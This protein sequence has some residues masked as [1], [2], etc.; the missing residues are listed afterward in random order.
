[1]ASLRDTLEC[2]SI[3][4]ARI[5]VLGDLFGHSAPAQMSANPE[6]RPVFHQVLR[7]QWNG[8]NDNAPHPQNSRRDATVD[9][10]VDGGAGMVMWTPRWLVVGAAFV[11]AS[12]TSGCEGTA[13]RSHYILESGV[14][15]GDELP[16]GQ[17]ICTYLSVGGDMVAADQKSVDW[18]G[19]LY[20]EPLSGTTQIYVARGSAEETAVGCRH[21]PDGKADT[22]AST[23]RG[24]TC[25]NATY[26]FSLRPFPADTTAD[27]RLV[28][29]AVEL[30]M[31][32]TATGNCTFEIKCHWIV[33][34]AWRWGVALG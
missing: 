5:S 23:Q 8:E 18:G 32:A 15:L 34:P 20:L 29:T 26:A 13:P 24:D 6:M 3:P 1:M 4:S 22:C 30:S 11:S 25:Q 31:D 12:V 16:V 14:G 17:P 21:A 2:W 28:P 19:G 27:P 9:R 33:R 10:C 7:P